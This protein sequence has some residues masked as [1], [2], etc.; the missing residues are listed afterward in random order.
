MRAPAPQASRLASS[1]CVASCE[2]YC[3]HNFTP[4]QR[5]AST[6][7]SIFSRR[8]TPFL[9]RSSRSPTRHISSI[10]A[11]MD[12][13]S[14]WLTTLSLA[15][16]MRVTSFPSVPA[17]THF[18]FLLPSTGQLRP[19]T[20]T[21][22]IRYPEPNPLPCLSPFPSSLLFPHQ[23]SRTSPPQPS[24]YGDQ[25]TPFSPSLFFTSPSPCSLLRNPHPSPP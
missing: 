17:S 16:H 8:T 21:R 10:A 20:R 23:N 2:Y 4:T 9:S 18:S 24:R 22:L 1:Q 11:Y 3:C 12:P 15:H 13:Q 19:R 14:T 6:I 5:R 7:I 25:P